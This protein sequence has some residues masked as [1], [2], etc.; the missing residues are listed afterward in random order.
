MSFKGFVAELPA[1]RGGANFDDNPS[2]VPITD[3]I[4][5]N[6]IVLED[7]VLR[8]EPGAAPFNAIVSGAPT[9]GGTTTLA[10]N[11]TGRLTTFTAT[12]GPSLVGT[13][14]KG[15]AINTATLV[16]T[17]ATGAAV[18]GLL[19]VAGG[20]FGMSVLGG[21]L[22]VVDSKGNTYDT[23][24]QTVSGALFNQN[25]VVLASSILTTALIAGDTITITYSTGNASVIAGIACAFTNVMARDR[26]AGA[27]TGSNGVTTFAVGPTLALSELPELLVGAIGEN[28]SNSAYAPAFGFVLADS[29]VNA[30]SSTFSLF[31]EYRVDTDAATS[32]GDALG[33]TPSLTA[34]LAVG[35]TSTAASV[36][37][38]SGGGL[39]P[40]FVKVV[41]KNFTTGTSATNG[42]TVITVP[43]AGV[44]AGN[45]LCVAVGVT[46]ATNVGVTDSKG[47]VYAP[48][49]P[50]VGFTEA[51][52]FTLLVPAGGLVSGDTITVTWQSQP[53]G[54]V[55]QAGGTVTTARRFLGQLTTFTGGA[56]AFAGV[57]A[58]GSTLANTD[59]SKLVSTLTIPVFAGA[60]AGGTLL[61]AAAVSSHGVAGGVFTKVIDSK[62]NIYDV[63]DQRTEGGPGDETGVLLARSTLTTPLVIGDTITIVWGAAFGVSMVGSACLFSGITGRDQSANAGNTSTTTFLVGPTGTLSAP[64]EMLVAAIVERGDVDANYQPIGAFRVGNDVLNVGT[65]GDTLSLFLQFGGNVC[66]GAVAAEFSNVAT[67]T[68][69]RSATTLVTSPTSLAV[70]TLPVATVPALLIGSIATGPTVAVTPTGGWT[71]GDRA[72]TTGGPP[73]LS[74]LLLYRVDTTS[75]TIIALDDWRPTS[76]LQRIVT[77][78]LDGAVYKELG[79]D[80]D[81][82]VLSSG[83]SVTAR[84]GRFIEA[85]K[86]AAA[87]NRKLFY[88]NG[89]DAVRFLDGDAATMTVL[90]GATQA[91]ADWSG[92]NQPI[93]GIVHRSRLI[94]FGNLNDPHRLY[95]ST[96]T[97]HADFRTSGGADPARNY[98]VYPALGDRIYGAA[99]YQG[100]P[101]F[102]K[103]PRGMFWF[104]DSDPDPTLWQ[105][106]QRTAAVGCAPSPYAVCPIDNDVLFMAADARFH[107][108]SSLREGTLWDSDLSAA[109]RLSPWIRANVNLSRL[110]Q[111]TSVWYPHKK[112]ALFGVPSTTSLTNDLTLVFDF[113][114][115]TVDNPLPR[116]FYSRRDAV[117]AL[118]LR[119]SADQIERPMLGE[120]GFVF[121]LDQDARNKGGAGYPGRYQTPHSDFRHIDPTL[122]G[123]KKIPAHLDLYC[124]PTSGTLTVTPVWDRVNQPPIT[125]DLTKR[126]QRFSHM[127]GSFYEGSFIVDSSGLADADHKIHRLLL[128]FAEGDESTGQT[129]R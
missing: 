20:V 92:T 8:H 108:L 66:V 3:L 7:G 104:D 62:G 15:S 36:L 19:V 73:F 44:A 14:A 113:L 114:E 10:R 47:N 128:A 85:G 121:L 75:P 127:T 59:Q 35:T 22:N 56:A 9:T 83:L 4:D 42:T 72:D 48:Q 120:A 21:V 70:S 6:G 33:N 41:G 88:L 30:G 80:L 50:A 5:A 38:F 1:G 69:A 100:V 86:E 107:L 29:V 109:L 61:V 96:T 71:T 28:Y 97:S 78:S 91:A 118:A 110:S 122:E 55:A 105:I 27:T 87:Q 89:T 2:R 18:G 64:P 13:V 24:D 74:G 103:W 26:A 84:P 82:V 95:F 94:L 54:T 51:L 68:A 125:F 90:N 129:G 93:N 99:T 53:S 23:E 119:L 102:W 60:G 126:R 40:A 77:A 67:P 11:F 32:I 57:V 115:S 65:G 49:I 124:T 34:T 106:Q 17:A 52:A 31:L 58:N 123:R 16:L 81:A 25:G 63:T 112:R 116:F 43:V 12:T 101:W 46:G 76:V 39:T 98:A 111:I 45:L 117:D 37:A 79:G